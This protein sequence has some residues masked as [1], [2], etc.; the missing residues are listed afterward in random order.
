MS[1]VTNAERQ[2]R[3]L[4]RSWLTYQDLLA[5]PATELARLGT[6]LNLD[7]GD[8]VDAAHYL[9]TQLNRSRADGPGRSVPAA[10]QPGAA[11]LGC[12]LQTRVRPR[13]LG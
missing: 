2:A 5:E 1:Y 9:T 6:E 12:H 7:L 10:T 8:T 4:P 11:C 3:H 13:H